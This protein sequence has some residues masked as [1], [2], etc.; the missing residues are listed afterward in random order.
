MTE[1]FGEERRLAILDMANQSRV[2]RVEDLSQRFG[3]SVSTVRRDLNDL[4]RQGLLRRT[5]GGAMLSRRESWELPRSERARQQRSAKEQIGILAAQLVRD[6]ETI[7][8]DSGTTTFA[9]ARWLVGKRNVTV[10]TNDLRIAI[11]LSSREGVRV[12][13]TGG[14]VSPAHDLLVGMAAERLLGEVNADRVFLATT[15]ITLERGATH[16]SAEQ[17]AIKRAMVKAAQEVVLVAD[18]SKVGR[19]QS[20]QVAPLADL[21]VLITDCGVPAGFV[22]AAQAAGLRVLLAQSGGTRGQADGQ[23]G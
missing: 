21:H 20:F 4:T 3:V 11:E 10:V 14:F 1:M 8:V 13:V 5:Y 18:S 9:L 23:S 19:V 17:L 15:G 16:A 6:G 22:S 2:V 7:I 12:L